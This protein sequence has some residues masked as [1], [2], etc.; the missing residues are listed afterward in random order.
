MHYLCNNWK[1]TIEKT[2]KKQ[3]EEEFTTILLVLITIIS[4]HKKDLLQS[5]MILENFCETRRWIM[6]LIVKDF[7]L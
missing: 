3:F 1:K 4:H 2:I 7:I 5:Y 6:K